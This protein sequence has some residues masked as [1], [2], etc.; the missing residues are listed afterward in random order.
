[1]VDIFGESHS[2]AIGAVVNGLKPGTPVDIAEINAFLARRRPSAAVYSTAR[3][4]TDRAAILSGVLNGRATGAPIAMMIENADTRSADYEKLRTVFRPSHSDYAA[5]VKYGGYNDFRGGGQFSGRLTAALCAAGGIALGVLKRRGIEITAYIA[6]VGG[7]KAAS[8]RDAGTDIGRTL[9]GGKIREIKSSAYP[10]LDK[11]PETAIIEE[12]RAASAAGDSVGGVIECAVTGLPAGVGEPVY[13]GME[14]ALAKMI[15]AIPAIKGVEFGAGFAAAEM[16]GSAA[17]DA[18]YFNGG[19]GGT[20]F[21][22]SAARGDSENSPPRFGDGTGKTVATRTNNNGGITGGI[23]NGMPVLFR[24]AVKPVPSIALEQ[25]TVDI[26]SGKN[27]KLVI[28][29]RHD[30]CIVPRAVPVIEAAAACVI[31]DLLYTGEKDAA[32]S[33]MRT[34]RK[35]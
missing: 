26:E 2:R 23:S 1:M 6:A 15:F 19:D 5:F 29:G 30:S 20:E 14:G 10:L 16:R 34:K 12:I 13:D 35:K 33:H 8:Y 28:S 22:D 7:V 21:S 25:D 31:L 27:T 9:C 4:E 32:F 24:T 17:N 11:S 18:M 3:R